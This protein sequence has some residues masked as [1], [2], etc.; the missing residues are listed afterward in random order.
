MFV[1]CTMNCN[2]I[3]CVNKR[4][5]I[6]IYVINKMW[7]VITGTSNLSPCLPGVN[8]ISFNN[9]LQSFELHQFKYHLTYWYNYLNT[10]LNE[11][12]LKIN[13][14]INCIAKP[15][16]ICVGPI[17]IVVSLIFFIIDSFNRSLDILNY[18]D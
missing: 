13:F 17:D 8:Q 11:V 12:Y 2:C 7:L 3:I 18:L 6:Y 16:M 4:A 14:T 5:I 9:L 10:I 15:L 1:S